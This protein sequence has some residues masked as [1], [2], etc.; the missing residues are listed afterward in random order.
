M[1][2]G[3]YT[4]EGKRFRDFRCSGFQRGSDIR[5]LMPP[6]NPPYSHYSGS[7]PL[8]PEVFEKACELADTKPT[9]RQQAKWRDGCGK[10]LAF[11]SEAK[12]LIQEEKAKLKNTDAQHEADHHG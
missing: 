2:G 12:R 9:R 8:D 11:R 5:I 7:L 6:L 3:M 1:Y 10:A 4:A